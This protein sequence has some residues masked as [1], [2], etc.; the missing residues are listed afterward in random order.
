MKRHFDLIFPFRFFFL[1]SDK[2]NNIWRGEAFIPNEYFPPDI[3]KFNAYAIHGQPES[4]R[5]YKSLFPSNA[6]QPDFH[7]L[8]FF[9]TFDMKIDQDTLSDFWMEALGKNCTEY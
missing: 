6:T 2:E 1:F 3:D 7:A 5:I 4:Q 9:Q 8:E